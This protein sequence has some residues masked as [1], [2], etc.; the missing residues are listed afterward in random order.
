MGTQY[1]L[2]IH[3]PIP[4]PHI[5]PLPTVSPAL[6]PPKSYSHYQSCSEQW[7]LQSMFTNWYTRNMVYSLLNLLSLK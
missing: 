3:S 2:Y 6:P 7:L 5:L 1:L 4:F